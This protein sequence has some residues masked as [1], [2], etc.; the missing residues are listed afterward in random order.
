[1]T[2][3]L[4]VMGVVG[5]APVGCTKDTDCKGERICEAG[6]CVNPPAAAT[7]VE[8]PAAASEAAP[9]PPP[10]PP[11]AAPNAA[12]YPKVVRKNGVTCIQSLGD[13]GVVRED[14]R[15]EGTNYSGTRH[16]MDAAHA[17]TQ[18]SSSFPLRVAREEE[19]VRSTVTADFGV[20][21]AMGILAAGG[22]SGVL[23]GL[24]AHLSVA[25]RLN[26]VAALGGALNAILNFGPGGF[27]GTFTL[28][29]ALRIGDEG[30]GTLILGPSLVVGST[31][32]GTA[33]ALAGS[34]IIHGVIPLSGG[35]GLHLQLGVTF[36][37]G[38][39]LL[40]LASGFG[41]SVF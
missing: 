13:D 14:C 3:W 39:A 23:P 27:A 17:S 10:P 26:G 6:Q 30:H 41:G 34:F 12:E 40:T 38:G 7:P 28:A 9:V 5:A 15:V 8:T 16:P 19:P 1:M 32:L 37:G 33:A 4:V 21:G 31:F 36:D 35:F 24:G 18:P 22:S 25:G 20:L 29:P 2:L 11:P